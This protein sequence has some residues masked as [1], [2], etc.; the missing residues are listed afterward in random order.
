MSASPLSQWH[1]LELQCTLAAVSASEAVVLASE[2][3]AARAQIAR[4]QCVL[5][6]KT[7]ENE[8]FEEAV[9]QVD[10]EG[11]TL[12]LGMRRWELKAFAYL[13]SQTI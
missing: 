9:G 11:Y 10:P 7:L 5:C 13:Q 1:K 3:A 2:F 8:I 12:V 6:K 4:L